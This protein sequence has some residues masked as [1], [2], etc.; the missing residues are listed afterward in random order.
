M[1]E[2]VLPKLRDFAGFSYYAGADSLN[3]GHL[4]LRFDA[5]TWLAF[6]EIQQAYRKFPQLGSIG[7]LQEFEVRSF[8]SDINDVSSMNIV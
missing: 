3:R 2:M 5:E 4:I 6:P 7:S 8:F 1:V